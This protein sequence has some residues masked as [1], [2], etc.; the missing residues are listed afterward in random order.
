MLKLHHFLTII[1]FLIAISLFGQ[2]F[3]EK[4]SFEGLEFRN[5]KNQIKNGFAQ[6]KL[7]EDYSWLP[8]SPI[9]IK[10]YFENG[11]SKYAAININK[12]E[13]VQAQLCCF[14]SKGLEY[15]VTLNA[16]LNKFSKNGISYITVYF[17][18]EPFDENKELKALRALILT[19]DPH[20]NDWQ[21]ISSTFVSEGEERYILIGKTMDFQADVLVDINRNGFENDII[22]DLQSI[23]VRLYSGQK[24]NQ[25]ASEKVEF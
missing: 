11:E 17:L 3:M 22:I 12:E 20:L 7:L 1:S 14:P 18:A 23:A 6:L 25:K 4:G 13:Y 8:Y 15:E 21:E 9:D 5:N 10:V 24:D 19:F 2:N 16:R